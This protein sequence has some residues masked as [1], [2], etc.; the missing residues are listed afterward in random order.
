MNAIELIETE[1]LERQSQLDSSKSRA[2]RNRQGQFATPPMLAEEI[3]RVCQKM[4]PH[5]QPIRFLDPAFGTGSFYSAL[6]RLLPADRIAHAQGFEIDEHYGSDA[7]NLWK[8]TR[9]QLTIA[10]FFVLDVPK[11]N[12]E[13]ANLLVCNPPYVR[14]H[15]IPSQAKKRLQNSVRKHVGLRLN[16]LAGLYCYF[17]LHAHTWLADDGLACWLVPSEFMDVNYGKEVKRYLSEQVTLLR[18]HRFD[19]HDVQ[20]DDALVSSVVVWFKK[21]LPQVY[22]LVEEHGIVGLT[23]GRSLTSPTRSITIPLSD[24]KHESKWSKLAERPPSRTLKRTILSD[25]FLIKRGL[26]TGA[27][28]FFILSPE[29]ATSHQIPSEFLVPI[30]PSPRYL[31]SDEI[32]ADEL[33]NPRLDK[34]LSLLNCKLPEG[35]VKESYPSLWAY[36]ETGK[37]QGIHTGYICTH[38]TPWYSQE[39][40][41]PSPL[42]CT[43]MGRSDTEASRAF[44][45]ILNRSRATAANVYLLLYPRSFVLKAIDDNPESLAKVVE[46]SQLGVH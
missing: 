40:R 20:F 30:L 12:E 36:F 37:R 23:F 46:S 6:L 14:H 17:M 29:E 25:L 42:L 32:A 13:K 21:S 5:D 34:K 41:P 35:Q 2:E 1:R 7:L 26:A 38:R 39:N 19:V 33:G 15:H 28:S 3:V 18:I 24:L 8:P 31:D 27:N 9:L 22:D 10:D 44:R 43:Y 16:G 45:F 4:L 11:T